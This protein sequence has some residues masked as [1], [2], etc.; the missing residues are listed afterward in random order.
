MSTTTSNKKDHSFAAIA[1]AIDGSSFRGELSR[2]LYRP[3]PRSDRK[4]IE[5]SLS[6]IPWKLILIGDDNDNENDEKIIS[7]SINSNTTA[8]IASHTQG[9]TNNEKDKGFPPGPAA[10]GGAA[11]QATQSLHSSRDRNFPSISYLDLR[12]NQNLQFAKD[13]CRIAGEKL[14]A[15]NPDAA[16]ASWK[17]ALELVPDHLASL[18]GYGAFLAETGKIGHAQTILE[19]ALAIDPGNSTAERFL[20]ELSEIRTRQRLG[21]SRPYSKNHQAFDPT[22]N[23]NKMSLSARESSAYQDA[24]LERKLM[25]SDSPEQQQQG[26]DPLAREEHESTDDETQNR[27]KRNRSRKKEDRHWKSSKHK[28]RYK[29]KYKHKSS[30][31]KG[32]RHKRRKRKEDRNRRRRRRRSR[33]SE[34]D[35][36]SE[37][38][39]PGDDSDH[40]GDSSSS[41]SSTGASVRKQIS[42]NGK[43]DEGSRGAS[44]KIHHRAQKRRRKRRRHEHS[45][46][47]SRK[48][49]S[50]RRRKHRHRDQQKPQE[51]V[52]HADEP[53]VDS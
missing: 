13:R 33:H 34:H 3:L 9:A 36:E 14:K 32:D 44:P 18:V 31:K 24:L 26:D 20:L 38:S 40:S 39:S 47:R 25:A 23:N 41:F 35:S 51:R 11:L 28:Q 19:Q 43:D 48:E 21:L 53:S 8:T 15:G 46:K 12:R 2:L 4:A 5:S 37:R 17:Q 1:T 6:V 49:S 30:E 16:R 50:G 52:E 10:A 29:D 42:D 22:T 27:S 7:S 45:H